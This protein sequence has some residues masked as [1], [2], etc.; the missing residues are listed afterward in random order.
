MTAID[1]TTV[2]LPGPAGDANLFLDNEEVMRMF[3]IIETPDGPVLDPGIEGK[4]PVDVNAPL[5]PLPRPLEQDDTARKAAF[6][7]VAVVGALFVGAIL[8]V[9]LAGPISAEEFR[10]R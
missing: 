10:R 9:G 5:V 4:F 8:L 6:T 1:E 7:A 2:V 3:A